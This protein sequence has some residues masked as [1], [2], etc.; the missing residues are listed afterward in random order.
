[1]FG[2]PAGDGAADMLAH[3]GMAGKLGQRR[4]AADEPVAAAGIEPGQD[5]DELAVLAGDDASSRAGEAAA[6]ARP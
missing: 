2:I 3:G 6:S 4:F 5:G 1:M